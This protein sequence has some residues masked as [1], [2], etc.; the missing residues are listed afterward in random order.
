MSDQPY[1][2]RCICLSCKS[3]QVFG[4]NF[5]SDPEFQAGM[6]EFWC[7]E[8]FTNLG[9]DGG[10]ISMALCSNPERS[11]YQEFAVLRGQEDANG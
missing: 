3:M 9:P 8:T 5:E 11:C 1:R 7:T 4:E 6:V 2:P 10:E